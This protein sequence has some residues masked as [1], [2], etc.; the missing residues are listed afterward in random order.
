MSET[1]RTRWNQRYQDRIEKDYPAPRR[2]LVQHTP[3]PKPGQ[4]ALDVACGQG[5]NALYLAEQGYTVDAVD[6]SQVAVQRARRE[7]AQRGLQVNFIVTDLDHHVF[8]QAVYD[9]IC[10]FYF[11]DRR[12]M[13]ALTATLRPGGLFIYETMNIGWLAHSADSNPD[14]LLRRGELAGFFPGWQVVLSEDAR[15]RSRYVGRKPL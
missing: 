5:Q 12:L 15:D 13:P 11:L 9:L 7:M 6:V 8:P 10:V 3:P 14:Y 2:L 1:D 4:R